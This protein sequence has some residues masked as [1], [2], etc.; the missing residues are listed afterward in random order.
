MNNCSEKA[1]TTIDF[2]TF[3]WRDAEE[4]A[5]FRQWARDQWV[6]WHPVVRDEVRKIVTE[7]QTEGAKS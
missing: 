5:K 3:S 1:Q 6:C 2:S 4:E 7:T